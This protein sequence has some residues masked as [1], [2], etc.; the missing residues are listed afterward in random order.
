MSKQSFGA[1]AGRGRYLNGCA[2]PDRHELAANYRGDIA[3]LHTL[4]F[5]GAKFDGCGALR[6]A[7][8]Y[9]ELMVATG[10]NYSVENCHWGA[11]GSIGCIDGD[12]DAACPTRTWAPF[13]W[14]AMVAYCP[15][16]GARRNAWGGRAFCNPL[17]PPVGVPR[18]PPRC[19]DA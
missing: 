15:H 7:T 19:F 18:P 5:D 4:G 9:A 13:N 14:C 1:T 11:G 17:N 6:N 8:L 3:A 2:C 16:V 10:K 12:D